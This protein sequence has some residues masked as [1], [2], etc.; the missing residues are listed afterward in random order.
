M[1]DIDGKGFF[2]GNQIPNNQITRNQDANFSV[3]I[4]FPTTEPLNDYLLW[5]QG[6]TG[7]GAFLGFRDGHFRLRAGDGGVGP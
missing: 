6:G 4:T 1:N 2:F 5:E 3:V 7:V